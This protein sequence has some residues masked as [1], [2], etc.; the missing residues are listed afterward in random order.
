MHAHQRPRFHVYQLLSDEG[1]ED[2]LQYGGRIDSESLNS[3][4]TGL[5]TGR[6]FGKPHSCMRAETCPVP[7]FGDCGV[8]T[9]QSAKPLGEEQS[10]V[11]P[12]TPTGDSHKPL[13]IAF[14]GRFEKFDAA[15]GLQVIEVSVATGAYTNKEAGMCP[16]S[17]VVRSLSSACSSA[18]LCLGFTHL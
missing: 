2:L 14:N 5:T 15:L 1:C 17:F 11:P 7:G 10:V 3:E 13:G 16:R 4:L 8:W 6:W 9:F 12:G 18:R